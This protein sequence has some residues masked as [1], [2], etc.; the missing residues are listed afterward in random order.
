VPSPYRLA[1]ARAITADLVAI[2]VFATIGL[3][4]HDKDLGVSGY[5]RDVLTIGGSWL[6][7]ARSTGLYRSP[8]TRRYLTTWIVGVTA[9]VAV[10]AIVLG[11]AI[12]GKEL[13]FLIVALI[14]TLLFTTVARSIVQTVTS[15][16]VAA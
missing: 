2:V 3:L 16:R 15:K 9:G 14:S 10:R 13:S 6:V 7:V 1:G 5:S 8:T 4:S 11:R 12:N